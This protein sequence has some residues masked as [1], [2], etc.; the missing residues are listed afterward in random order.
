MTDVSRVQREW[1][2][3]I[4][5]KLFPV[6]QNLSEALF[7]SADWSSVPAPLRPSLDEVEELGPPIAR[8]L[9]G[10][11]A[12]DELKDITDAPA[13][14]ARDE[15]D[16]VATIVLPRITMPARGTTAYSAWTTAAPP[17]IKALW[18]K[19]CEYL[20]THPRPVE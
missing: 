11:L 7:E 20:D 19:L 5:A 12:A 18:V 10:A 13:T 16:S 17:M 14:E 8:A 1:S 4:G 9:A 6:S 15:E 2:A 3:I